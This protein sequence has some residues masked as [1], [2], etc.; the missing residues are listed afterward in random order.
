M[1]DPEVSDRLTRAIQSGRLL[2]ACDEIEE[3]VADE[4]STEAA[5]LLSAARKT[6]SQITAETIAVQK[7]LLSRFAALGIDAAPPFPLKEDAG[8]QYHMLSLE[9]DGSKLGEILEVLD[10]EGFAIDDVLKRKWRALRACASGVHLMA[11]DEASTRLNLNWRPG[12]SGLL[13]KLQP[14]PA[15]LAFLPVPQALW[16]L[17][18]LSKPL[19]K[20]VETLSGQRVADRLGLKSGS[21]S[22]GTPHVLLDA[23]FDEIGV[24]ADD[25]VL[26]LGCGD[27]RILIAAAKRFGCKAVGVERNAKLVAEARAAA[28]EHGVG[29]LVTII[30]GSALEHPLG[31]A[32]VVFLFLPVGLL[33]KMLSNIRST[34]KPDTR[35][36]A[37][38]QHRLRVDWQPDRQVPIMTGNAITV[39]HV[40]TC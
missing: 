5:G 21:F 24:T 26:D 19:R 12:R 30:E 39:A 32:N 36:I 23:L 6:C 10:D 29:E 34:A 14:A 16:P 25:T 20:L 4:L 17:Y 27:G 38:E 33:S 9:V 22:L 13:G 8:L 18:Y 35:I 2:A 7:R 3:S 1:H 31:Q 28:V 40:W 37:H 11:W 15:D